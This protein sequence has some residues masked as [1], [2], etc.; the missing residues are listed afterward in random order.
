[1]EQVAPS[2]MIT[3]T[4]IPTHIPLRETCFSGIIH[5]MLGTLQD[6][7]TP[8]ET[9]RGTPPPS[10]AMAVGPASHTT[11]HIGIVTPTATQKSCSG[12]TRTILGRT[13]TIQSPS[14]PATATVATIQALTHTLLMRQLQEIKNGNLQRK[15]RST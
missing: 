12:I 9:A 15:G 3:H 5:M 6:P 4:G 10:E 2:H 11:I 7:S 13:V 14:I 1:M 8:V